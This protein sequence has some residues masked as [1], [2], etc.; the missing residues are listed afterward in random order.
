MSES[1]FEL[2]V[3]DAVDDKDDGDEDWQVVSK[4]SPFPPNPDASHK[5]T[6][7]ARR[8]HRYN[9]R[10]PRVQFTVFCDTTHTHTT[11]THTMRR[12]HSL[13][14]HTHSRNAPTRTHNRR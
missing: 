2:D 7:A 1:D 14:P 9:R 10:R 12:T 5:A 11:H 3:S 8:R 4:P 6:H 13:A